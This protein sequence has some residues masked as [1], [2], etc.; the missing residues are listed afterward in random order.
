MALRE[1]SWHNDNTLPTL[2]MRNHLILERRVSMNRLITAALLVGL[3]VPALY[4]ADTPPPSI[5]VGDV[6]PDFTLTD[7][8]GNKVSLHDFKGKKNV[9]LA[10]Y[11][12]A[13]T[14]G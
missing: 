14:G 1:G 3:L 7:Q 5:K 6:A 10:F 13:F 2:E 9:A 11:I 4:A 8:N 12:F